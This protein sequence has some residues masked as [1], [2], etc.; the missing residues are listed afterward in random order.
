MSLINFILDLA[1]LLLALSWRSVRL[2]PLS[3]AA[4]ATL[5]GTV[6]RAEPRRLKRWHLLACLVA[7][8]VGRALFYWQ[9]GPAVDWTPRI[10]LGMV[11]L[12]FRG[13]VFLKALM[14]SLASFVRAWLVLYTW[15]VVLVVIQGRAQHPD[16]LLKLILLQLGAVARWPTWLLAVLPGAA[17]AAVWTGACP[18]LIHAD[19][20]HRPQ[21][22]VHLLAQG[23]LMGVGIY[24]TL[25]NLL[26]IILFLHLISSYVYLGSNPFWE[27]IATTARRLL[28]PLRR[29]PLRLGRFDFA[30]LAGI[31]TLLL[32]L[33]AL[34]HA[35]MLVLNRR[36][37]TLWPQ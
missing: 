10:D 23:G 3:R 31:V 6:K 29:L 4:A 28:R 32:L 9:V 22:A 18:L 37:L 26:P 14:F 33:Q 13:D 11:A 20:I 8:L 12:A 25:K 5:A 19:V 21:S 36:G 1:A 17:A 24:F 30:P 27:F 34:P 7:L 15:L 2:D 35:V 16:P